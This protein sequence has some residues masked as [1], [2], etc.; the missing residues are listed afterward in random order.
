MKIT[1]SKHRA[2]PGFWIEQKNGKQPKDD[3]GQG[4]DDER[5]TSSVIAAGWSDGSVGFYPL[6]EVVSGNSVNTLTTDD[7]D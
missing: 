2:A 3:A 4:Q 1:L 7:T 6:P 5:S